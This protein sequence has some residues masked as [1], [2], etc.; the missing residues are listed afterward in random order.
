MTELEFVDLVSCLMRVVWAAAAG[1]LYLA[2][3]GIQVSLPFPQPLSGIRIRR[4]LDIRIRIRIRYRYSDVWILEK[5]C[6]LY[7]TSKSTRTKFPD[8]NSRIYQKIFI[9]G[10]L[11][12]CADLDQDSVTV[13]NI[14]DGPKARAGVHRTAQSGQFHRV[15]RFPRQ[16]WFHLGPSSPSRYGRYLNLA[17]IFV[18]F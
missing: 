17:A 10:R 7:V 4:F 13:L 9:F 5:L 6:I 18:T 16:R 12:N 2:S 15:Q 14:P 1:K 11:R 8:G 3:M